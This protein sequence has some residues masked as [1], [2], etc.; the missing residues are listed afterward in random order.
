MSSA[1]AAAFYNAG[2]GERDT[3]TFPSFLIWLDEDFYEVK[4]N[5]V[6]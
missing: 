4:L 6:C 5:L 2:G 1:V 3:G